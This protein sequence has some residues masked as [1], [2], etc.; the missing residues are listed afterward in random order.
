MWK[1]PKYPSI[2]EWLNKVLHIHAMEYYLSTESHE[3][4]THGITSMN[5]ENM[6]LNE[7]SQA[8]KPT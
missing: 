6:M 4:L 8:Q 1:Q 2:A 7:I 5:L 3:G